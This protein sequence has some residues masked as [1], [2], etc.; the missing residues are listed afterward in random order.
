MRFLQ[1][2]NTRMI[3]LAAAISLGF[4]TQG[5]AQEQG[6]AKVHTSAQAQ[7]F[8]MNATE[9]ASFQTIAPRAHKRV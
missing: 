7:V 2:D 9:R 6:F 1:H 5:E 3:A 8:L 4:W